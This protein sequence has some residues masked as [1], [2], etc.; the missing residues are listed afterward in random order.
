MAKIISKRVAGPD[1]PIY[2]GR[3]VLSPMS[4]P[5]KLKKENTKD[6]KKGKPTS[7]S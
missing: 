1:D 4:A 7:K 3:W 2:T 6:N 5:K